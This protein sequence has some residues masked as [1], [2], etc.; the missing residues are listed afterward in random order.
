[1]AQLQRVSA[2]PDSFALAD[3]TWNDLLPPPWLASVSGEVSI[4]GR[5]APY[6]HLRSGQDEQARRAGGSPMHAAGRAGADRGGQGSLAPAA[7]GGCAP[8]NGDAGACVE[9]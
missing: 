6:R 2:A 7:P 3:Q 9:T 8:L 5:Q 1:M 4:A